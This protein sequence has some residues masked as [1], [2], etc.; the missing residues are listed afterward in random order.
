M[1]NSRPRTTLIIINILGGLLVLASYAWGFLVEPKAGDILWGG[2]PASLRPVYTISMFLAA[3]G[4]FVF[5]IFILHLDPERTKILNWP[6]FKVFNILFAVILI[7]SALWL[8][9]TMLALNHASQLFVWFV[10]LDLVL[11]A[12]G[13]LGL[14]YA[15]IKVHPR[16]TAWLQRL[17]IIGGLL[18]IFQTVIL[19][20]VIWAANFH[21]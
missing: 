21:P 12:L 20:A 1:N 17:A 5:S 14:L 2:V 3:A 15:L 10:R 11:V 8:P 4:Y 18:F 7:P 9:L 13:S 16:K 6:G 19:D